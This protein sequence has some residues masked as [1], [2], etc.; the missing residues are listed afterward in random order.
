M[1]SLPENI[2]EIEENETIENVIT[3]E[4]KI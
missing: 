3:M 1:K 4:V 2:F